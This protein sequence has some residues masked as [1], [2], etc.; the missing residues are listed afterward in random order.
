MHAH[1]YRPLGSMHLLQGQHGAAGNRTLLCTHIESSAC[2]SQLAGM[3]LY[4]AVCGY[5]QCSSRRPRIWLYVAICNAHRVVC[6]PLAARR[7][8]AVC[9]FLCRC[10]AVCCFIL[11]YISIYLHIYIY[12]YIYIYIIYMLYIYIYVSVRN[13]P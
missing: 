2:L 3:W 13:N 1:R 5:M 9:G 7:R 4:V 11:L 10:V 6:L 12:M 8:A